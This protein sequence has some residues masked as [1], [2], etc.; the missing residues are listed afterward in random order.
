MREFNWL[1]CGFAFSSMV[2][3]YEDCRPDYCMEWNVVLT[4]EVI[5]SLFGFLILKP[6]LLPIGTVT[7]YFRP[8]LRTCKV[9]L[10][11][12]EPDIDAFTIPIRVFEWDV[13]SPF[14]IPSNSFLG[15]TP[16][17][18]IASSLH[19]RSA[20]K[21]GDCSQHVVQGLFGINRVDRRGGLY[22]NF[23]L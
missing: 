14:E 7:V 5:M 17:R 9:T 4:K 10:N 20:S 8:N 2:K 6:P 21:Q 3:A 15:A 16:C 11:C 19:E 12:L 22:L 13:N 23:N 1:V 18:A